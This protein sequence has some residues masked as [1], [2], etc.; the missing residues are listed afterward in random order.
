MELTPCFLNNLSPEFYDYIHSNINADVYQLLLKNDFQNIIEKNIAITQIECRQKIKNKLPFI[1]DNERFLFPSK[2]LAEQSTS[3]KLALFHSSLF[4]GCRSV[5]DMTAGLLID[6]YFIS[7]DGIAVTAIEIN[8]ESYEYG[9]HNLNVLDS[10]IKLISGDSSEFIKETEEIFDAIFIDPARRGDNNKKL[11]RIE[12]CS[13]NIADLLDE[14]EKK[15]NYIIVKASPMLD[16]TLL[17]NKFDNLSDIWILSINNDCKEVLFKIDFMRVEGSGL[18]IHTANYEKASAQMFDY[19]DCSID[20]DGLRIYFPE[21]N[22]FLYEPNAS[23]MKAGAFVHLLRRF[24]MLS[25]L[26]VNTHLFISDTFIPEFPGRKFRIKEIIPFKEKELKK[27]RESYKTINVSVRNFRLT[28]D[29][30]KNK[31]KIKDG[32][33]DYLFGSILND[34][35]AYLLICTKTE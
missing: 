8:K 32:G 26:H 7:K 24:P 12:D 17:K 9:L 4:A 13:P 27:I 1:F 30:L 11:Y 22:Q 3:E 10:H 19:K 34:D 18:T 14:L 29:L 20:M 31:L 23:I 21:I 33:D 35:K 2:L 5:L 25:K 16:I 6:S 15:S 28:A